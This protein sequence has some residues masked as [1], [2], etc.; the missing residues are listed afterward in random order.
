MTNL[1]KLDFN[2]R[3]DSLNPVAKFYPEGKSLWQYPQRQPLE[4]QIAALYGLSPAQVLCTNGGDEAIMI[5]MRIIKESAQLIL[6]LPAFSQYTWGITSWSLDAVQIQP[7]KNEFAIDT[8]GIISAIEN[9]QNSIV[10]LTSPNNPTGELIAFDRLTEIIQVSTKNN[11]WVFLDEAY[12]EF[13]EQGSL[14]KTLLTQCENLVILR[15]LSKAYGLAGIRL[16]YILGSEKLISKFAEKCMPFNIPKPSL[17]IASK[18]LSVENQP[19]ILSYCQD[20]IS[21]RKKLIKWLTKIGL[22]I[23]PSQANFVMLNLNQSQAKATAS[24]FAK[25]GVVIRTFTSRALRNSIRITI[26]YQ[27]ELLMGLLKQCLQPDLVCLDM[28]GVLVDTRQ[29]Y[30]QCVIETVKV[31]SEQ[32]ITLGLIQR[33]RNAG[34]FNNE[35]LL[36]QKLLSNLGFDICLEEVTETFQRIYLGINGKGLCLKEKSLLKQNLRNRILKSDCTI[37]SIVTGRP[38]KEAVNGQV[39][40][41]LPELDLVSLDDVSVAKPS[42]EGIKKL[43]KKYS[44]LS[45]MCGDNVDDMQAALASNSLAIGISIEN[46][47]QLYLAGADIVLENINQLEPWLCQIKL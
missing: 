15:T 43:Q 30:D 23:M 28:D 19:A 35:W 3:C 9:T 7:L 27:I 1:L 44:N 40:I 2:E 4:N 29:S 46:S 13:S 5:L 32:R 12:I 41:G 14:V 37:F 11:S 16:G 6:P 20:I 17:D 8:V 39:L 42:P 24:F 33:L 18:A 31:L 38:R 21:N 10:V 22:T 47:E 34:G 45:W 26:P 25:N 36:S